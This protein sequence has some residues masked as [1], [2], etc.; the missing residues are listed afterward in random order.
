MGTMAAISVGT[1]VIGARKQKKAGKQADAIAQQNARATERETAETI[2]RTGA[3][4]EQTLA[5]TRARSGASG[6]VSG[7]GSTTDFL[8]EMQ[9]TFQE[10]LDWIQESGGSRAS[11]ERAEGR[12]AKK[13]ASAAAWGTIASGTSS[14]MGYWK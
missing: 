10:D 1:S 3:A 2:K 4:Q 9:K 13:Q 11:I 5:S 6:I 7:A 12:M 14:M 8:D